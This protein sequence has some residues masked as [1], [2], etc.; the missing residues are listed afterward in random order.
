[1]IFPSIRP[2]DVN[3]GFDPE[4]LGVALAP[5]VMALRFVAYAGV[6]PVFEELFMRSFVIRVA[7]TWNSDRDFS[8]RSDRVLQLE[9]FPDGGGAVYDYPYSMGVV[10]HGA[11]GRAQ[12]ALAVSPQTRD[13]RHRASRGDQWRDLGAGGALR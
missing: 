13:G 5:A 4:M 1:M 12:H 9:E 3:G 2:E 8:R 6:T 10:G 7:E 11:V